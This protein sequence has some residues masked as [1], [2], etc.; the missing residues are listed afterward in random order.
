MLQEIKKTEEEALK[1]A[2]EWA[3][4]EDFVAVIE[5]RGEFFV[6]NEASMVRNWERVVKTF[7][8]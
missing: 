7:E 1:L 2:R 4:T 3:K 8:K 6:E 5:S